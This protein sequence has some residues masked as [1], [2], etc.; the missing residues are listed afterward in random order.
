MMAFVEDGSRPFDFV[1]R[2]EAAPMGFRAWII[3]MAAGLPYD[4]TVVMPISM[5]PA[6]TPDMEP[7]GDH[8]VLHHMSVDLA[9][10]E[11]WVLAWANR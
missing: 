9:E 8:A 6:D 7:A 5:V 10:A 3:R 11:D 2:L 4:A 1:E